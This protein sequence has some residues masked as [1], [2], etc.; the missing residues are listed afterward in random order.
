MLYYIRGVPLQFETE[1]DT[2][3][4][5]VGP[6]LSNLAMVATFRPTD[7]LIYKEKV[8]IKTILQ[9][10]L[11]FSLWIKRQLQYVS[12]LL[13][14]LNLFLEMN[15]VDINRSDVQLDILKI[16]SGSNIFFSKTKSAYDDIPIFFCEL[17][18]YHFNTEG[19]DDEDKKTFAILIWNFV[20][21]NLQ[22]I[23]KTRDII[24]T[25]SYII[26]NILRLR[27]FHQCVENQENND[28]ACYTFAVIHIGNKIK[29]LMDK[30]NISLKTS[31]IEKYVE[32]VI[33]NA[34]SPF[35]DDDSSNTYD[36]EGKDIK[37]IVNEIFTQNESV[38]KS[39]LSQEQI[40]KLINTTLKNEEDKYKINMWVTISF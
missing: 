30:Y 36:E 13:S 29:Q 6:L 8:N 15:S 33:L 24:K 4:K 26:K 1:D 34:K 16:F 3:R 38:V 27:L 37:K 21:Y 20:T 22:L 11:F 23:L 10:D 7:A 31:N 12:N 5:F 32:A 17:L 18:E 39:Y 2:L 35:Y 28:I 14:C 19:Y 40:V 9:E 25:K